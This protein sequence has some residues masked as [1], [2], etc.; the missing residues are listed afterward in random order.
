MKQ[1]TMY[2]FLREALTRHIHETS[3]LIEQLGEEDIFREPIEGS[4]PLGEVV[5]HLLRSI[6]YYSR[7]LAEANWD[8]LP[9]ALEDYNSASSIKAL[10]KDVFERTKSYIEKLASID[11]SRVVDT[12]NRP[13]TLSEILLELIEHSIHHRGQITVY[14]R[15]LGIKPAHI[16]YIL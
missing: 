5:L 3:P 16:P 4:R 12:F 7:G 8:P 14:Y 15:L 11:L 13:T 2:E 1:I 10:A 9:Y 6:E